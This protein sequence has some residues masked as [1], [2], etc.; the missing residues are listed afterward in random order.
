MT[1]KKVKLPQTQMH[2][3]NSLS[4]FQLNGVYFSRT[5]RNDQKFQGPK[6]SKTFSGNNISPDV[7]DFLITILSPHAPLL[8]VYFKILKF[9]TGRTLLARERKEV[10]EVSD[11]K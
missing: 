4:R 3:P 7:S 9:Q 10:E 11:F 6:D 5:Q 1:V 8:S 2:V